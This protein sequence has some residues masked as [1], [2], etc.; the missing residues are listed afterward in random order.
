[1]KK[2]TNY[3]LKM[4]SILLFQN[5]LQ[6]IIIALDLNKI[7]NIIMFV[8]VTTFIWIRMIILIKESVGR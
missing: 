4:T 5:I 2:N 6:L 3:I 7:G 1:M 8:L